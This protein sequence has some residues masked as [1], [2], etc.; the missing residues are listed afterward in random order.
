MAWRYERF[1]N[2]NRAGK[3]HFWSRDTHSI[4]KRWI[5]CK[6]P[7]RFQR[8]SRRS[9]RSELCTFS[10]KSAPLRHVINILVDKNT[11]SPWQ[12][13]KFCSHRKRRVK[14]WSTRIRLSAI[15]CNMVWNSRQQDHGV[16]GTIAKQCANCLPNRSVFR[17]FLLDH[18]FRLCLGQE[19]YYFSSRKLIW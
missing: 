10:L 4:V 12:A 13:G 8:L 15:G 3:I 19:T 2:T 18:K 7:E 1:Q 11:S 9:H 16:K 5:S 17:D 6:S 14:P